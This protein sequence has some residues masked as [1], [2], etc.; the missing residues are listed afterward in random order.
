MEQQRRL[1]SSGIVCIAGIIRWRI[2]TRVDIDMSDLQQFV[3]Q[4]GGLMDITI[5][6]K[7]LEEEI[8][9]TLYLN[10]F[11]PVEYQWMV[12]SIPEEEF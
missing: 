8:V 6:I 5:D 7:I 2:Q 11:L 1:D 12:N 9:R 3:M 10:A 4:L